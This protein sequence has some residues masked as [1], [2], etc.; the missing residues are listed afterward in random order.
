MK[1]W[2]PRNVK[3]SKKN[4]NFFKPIRFLPKGGSIAELV[5]CL[6]VVSKV[7]GWNLGAN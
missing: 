6:P 4:D 7:R 2:L 1:S 3:F 5:V